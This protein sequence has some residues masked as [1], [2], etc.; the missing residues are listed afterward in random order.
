MEEACSRGALEHASHARGR[1]RRQAAFWILMRGAVAAAQFPS[2]LRAGLVHGEVLIRRCR[3]GGRSDH[4][5]V[6][7]WR[8]ASTG[9]AA[10]AVATFNTDT[11]GSG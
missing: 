8:R 1:G 3:R 4:L 11:W 7:V 5:R 6:C 9:A 10:A 2:Q